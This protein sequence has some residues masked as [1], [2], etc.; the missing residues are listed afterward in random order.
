[1]RQLYGQRK[2]EV[3]GAMHPPV[4]RGQGEDGQ[5]VQKMGHDPGKMLD[6]HH[7]ALA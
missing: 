1:M 3:P 5:V 7:P 4:P 2:A 6:H